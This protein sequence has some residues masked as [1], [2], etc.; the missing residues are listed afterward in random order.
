MSTSSLAVLE[1]QI[2]AL[3]AAIASPTISPIA[4]EPISVSAPTESPILVSPS[5]LRAMI[6]E[7]IATERPEVVM[8]QPEKEYTLM[9]ALSLSLTGEEQQWLIKEEVIKGVA[10]FMATDKGR[11]LIKQFILDYR[12]YYV[13]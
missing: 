7:A 5:D 10:N 3:K 2:G 12:N 1:Q 11:S 4:P 9:E 6:R 8:K 13:G